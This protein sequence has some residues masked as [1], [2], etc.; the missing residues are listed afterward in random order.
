MSQKT[1]RYTWHGKKYEWLSSVVLSRNPGINP[2]DP[3]YAVFASCFWNIDVT[4]Q[5]LIVYGLG[6]RILEGIKDF[7]RDF[8]WIKKG[9][10]ASIKESGF[11]SG[12]I[13]STRRNW[14][15]FDKFWSHTRFNQALSRLRVDLY[16]LADKEKAASAVSNENRYIEPSV[17]DV[18]DTDPAQEEEEK[19][20]GLG[21]AKKLLIVGG[22][23]VILM[24]IF[25]RKR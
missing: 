23:A 13:K 1:F 8:D 20:E 21:T 18:P 14:D 15:T 24:L 19:N 11:L 25:K 2:Q 12:G 17:P 3:T 6:M 16:A 9:I 4:K 22:A 10:F 7:P 5:K